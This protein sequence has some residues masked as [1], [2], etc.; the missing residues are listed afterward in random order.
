MPE[1]DNMSSACLHDTHVGVELR[2]CND[3]SCSCMCHPVTVADV[4]PAADTS[5]RE[6]LINGVRYVPAS[7]DH[8]YRG[9]FPPGPRGPLACACGAVMSN[10][11]VTGAAVRGTPDGDTQ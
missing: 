8:V 2:T 4:V 7:H 10:D 3:R 1:L 5:Q 6:V 9:L 11:G